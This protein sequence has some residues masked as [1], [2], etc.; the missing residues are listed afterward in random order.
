MV[1]IN[2]KSPQSDNLFGRRYSGAVAVAIVPQ[3]DPVN[4]L[5]QENN[6]APLS[7][8]TDQKHPIVEL[9]ANMIEE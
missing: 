2:S 8:V 3:I 6:N 9:K 5:R 1:Q 4:N 7:D